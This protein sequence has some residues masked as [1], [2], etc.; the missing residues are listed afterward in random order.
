MIQDFWYNIPPWALSRILTILGIIIILVSINSLAK[1]SLK[2][3]K[4]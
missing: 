4:K 1:S 3:R 2:K